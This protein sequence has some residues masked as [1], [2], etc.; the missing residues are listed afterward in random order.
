MEGEDIRIARFRGAEKP[1]GKVWDDI[2]VVRSIVFVLLL[3]L[4]VDGIVCIFLLHT[5]LVARALAVPAVIRNPHTPAFVSIISIIIRRHASERENPPNFSARA[6]HHRFGDA[7]SEVEFTLD[8]RCRSASHPFRMEHQHPRHLFSPR[9]P[10]RNN[11][12]WL[13][14]TYIGKGGRMKEQGREK[15]DTF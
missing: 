7:H 13:S 8:E 4:M 14:K 9:F 11:T 12:Y 3:L 5:L 6:Q 2:S 15:E 10:Y 1:R